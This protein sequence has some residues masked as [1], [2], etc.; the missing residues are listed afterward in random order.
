MGAYVTQEFVFGKY[1]FS[2]CGTW[3]IQ[4]EGQAYP[5]DDN[6]QN[7]QALLLSDDYKPEVVY[8]GKSWD[9]MLRTIEAYVI[10]VE[11]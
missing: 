3:T 10:A 8:E 2:I 7:W 5:I 9:E 4:K 1:K 11:L 6:P